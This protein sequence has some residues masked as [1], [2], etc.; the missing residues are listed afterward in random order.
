MSSPPVIEM[1]TPFAPFIETPS[2]SGLLIAFS[3]ASIA[4]LSPSA[5]PVPIIALPISPMTE[6]TS[7]KSRLI[8]PGMTIKS[9]IPRT[10]CCSTSSAISNASLNV[11][12]GL[13]MRNR[14]WFGMTISVS[15]C[16][17]SS[18]MP[19]SAALLRR[20]PSKLNG[21]VTTPTVRIPRSRAAFA[22]TGAAPVPVP[23]PMPA[24]MKHICAPSSAFSTCSIVSSAAARP[25]SGREPAPRPC[26][27][28][29]PS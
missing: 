9:V 16:F 26:V 1:M 14:F 3:A 11:V 20:E 22:M 7:A 21:L 5:S 23:P 8:R 19:A 10:P 2:S 13:A 25:I 15:T 4:R 18:A 6:R 27:I 12:D 24:A 29:R 28:L 17:C